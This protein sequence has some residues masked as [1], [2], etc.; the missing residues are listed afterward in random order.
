MTAPLARFAGLFVPYEK[1]LGLGLVHRPQYAYCMWHA[2][3]LAQ[4]LG[5]ERI[6]VLEFGVAGG[7]GLVAI[8]Q[9][10][11]EIERRLSVKFEIYGFDAGSGLPAPEDYR[12]LPYH[13]RAGFFKMDETGLR[14]R[15]KRSKLVLGPVKDT[16]ASFLDQ[17]KPPPVGCVFHDLD[18]YSSTR[19]ALQ[20]FD[21]AP[22]FFL[23]R[24][25]NYFDDTIGSET[26][27]YND[28]TGQRL[29]INEFNEKHATKKVSRCYH[30][31]RYIRR[32]VW[33][34]QVFVLHDFAHPR[35]NAFV[36]DENQQ[37]PLE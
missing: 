6:S 22:E 3:K 5:H 35:Y 24:L 12:D 37:L 10:A 31:A 34:E 9:H 27:L 28:F 36:S 11:A 21:G 4:R 25:F 8:E 7:N 2:G 33:H 26:E 13:W 18:F 14:A 20:V 23:P 16:A 29:A 19:D 17:H 1:R 30:L 32:P 15:L